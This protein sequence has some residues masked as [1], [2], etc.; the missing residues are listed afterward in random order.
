[1]PFGSGRAGKKWPAPRGGRPVGRE[2]VTVVVERP[3]KDRTANATML[4]QGP[5]RRKAE[6]AAP[7]GL[8]EF[9]PEGQGL[10]RKHA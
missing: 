3:D 10:A 5:S 6:I 8:G 7:G 9:L 4:A 1:M 2:R